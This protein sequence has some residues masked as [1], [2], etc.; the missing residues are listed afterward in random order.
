MVKM[1]E[2]KADELFT[3]LADGTVSPCTIEDVL[4]DLL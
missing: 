3:L 4:S 2:Q 1:N